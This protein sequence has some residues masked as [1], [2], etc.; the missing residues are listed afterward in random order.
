MLTRDDKEYEK[1]SAI[2]FS[3]IKLIQQPLPEPVGTGAKGIANAA[4]GF[5][6][7]ANPL[8]IS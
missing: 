6:C 3:P 2:T 7:S 8:R 1:G 4:R 5:S